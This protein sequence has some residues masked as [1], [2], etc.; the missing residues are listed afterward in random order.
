MDLTIYGY[1]M[2]EAE[3][4]AEEARLGAD[5]QELDYSR[6]NYRRWLSRGLLWTKAYSEACPEGEYGSTPIRETTA[7]TSD[8]FEKARD[9]GWR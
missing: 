2:T 5:E 7:I 3:F 9:N 8:E 6:D 1:A 4:L